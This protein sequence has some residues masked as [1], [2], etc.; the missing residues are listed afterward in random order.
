VPGTEPQVFAPGL[1]SVAETGETAADIQSFAR[2]Y[3]SPGNRT[4]V[5]L[6]SETK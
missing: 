6:L 5:R 1:V 4:V 2:H 3:L